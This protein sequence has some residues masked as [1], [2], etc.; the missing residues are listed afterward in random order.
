[1]GEEPVF[2]D[3]AKIYVKGGDGGNGVVAFRREKFVPYGGP[4]GGNGGKGGDVYLVVDPSLNT[5]LPFKY[6]VHFKAQRGEHGSGKNKT[7]ASGKDLEVRVPPGTLVYDAETGKLLADLTRPGQRFLAA[8]GGRGG[9]GNAAFKSPTKQA[10][11]LAE[12][13]EPGEERWLILELKLIADVGIVGVPN[14]GKSTLLSKV[15]AAKP[16]IA[17]YPFTTV[18]PQLG[19]A[20]VDDKDFVLADIPG[21]L[22]GAHKGVGLGDRFLKHIERTKVL[23]H[24]LNGLSPDPV[25]DWE[26]INQEL[27][28]FNPALAGKPQ[29]VAF[30]K[31]DIP[32]V[33]E[34]FPKVRDRLRKKGVGEVFP[35]SA[36][37]VE[38]VQELMRRVLKTLEELPEEPE[39]EEEAVF[40]I[41]EDENA[42][43]ITRE[44]DGAWRVTGKKVE[45]AA[46]MTNWDYYEA[47]MR[48]QRI[49]EALGVT[50]ALE[51][52]GVKDGDVVRIGN[53]E[54]VWGWEED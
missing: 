33:R 13:G 37:T 30:N 28:L 41:E 47:A 26:A 21:L 51:E 46:A 18:V 48:F 15:T 2:Y 9:R 27:E 16:K 36:L 25:G 44:E 5:L 11:R 17:D 49:L 34:A 38:G 45:R 1:M 22:E 43:Q 24:L 4:S 7:G 23:I 3:R 12:K 10:P 50:Q 40:T 52:A 14:A 31:I 35:I 53:T 19:V 6:K 39:I 42:F 54:L 8:K 29:V 32:E 20:V